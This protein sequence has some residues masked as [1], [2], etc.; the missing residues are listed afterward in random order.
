MFLSRE[1]KLENQAQLDKLQ[2]L[3][4]QADMLSQVALPYHEVCPICPGQLMLNTRRQV[5]LHLQSTVHKAREKEFK[6]LQDDV[7]TA[8]TSTTS[9]SRM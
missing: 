7:S 5:Y 6:G 2:S 1:R 8:S 3:Y 4:R 9:T